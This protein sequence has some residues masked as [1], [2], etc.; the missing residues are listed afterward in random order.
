MMLRGAEEQFYIRQ[1]PC[2]H[3]A[4]IALVNIGE[5]AVAVHEGARALDQPGV[6]S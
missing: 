2:A 4:P 6:P 3:G 1:C 5:S